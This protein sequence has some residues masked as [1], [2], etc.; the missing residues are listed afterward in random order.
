MGMPGFPRRTVE[1]AAVDLIEATHRLAHARAESARIVTALEAR[2]A[3]N[4]ARIAEYAGEGPTRKQDSG[5]ERDSE[6]APQA[7]F[8]QSQDKP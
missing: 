2:W 6:A 4:R 1:D 3:A 5:C 8:L 7:L